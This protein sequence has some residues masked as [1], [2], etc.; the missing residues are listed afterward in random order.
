MTNLQV[1]KLIR[2]LGLAVQYN[3]GEWKVNYRRDDS[4]RTPDSDYFTDDK[5]DAIGTARVMADW[6]RE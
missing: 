5:D 3:D 1:F 2:S 4:R 6:K